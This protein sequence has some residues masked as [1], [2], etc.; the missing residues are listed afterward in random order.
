MPRPDF[1]ILGAPKCGTTAMYRWLDA[2]PGVFMP[3]KE[4]HHWGGDLHHRRATLT[5]EAYQALFDDAGP[6]QVVGEVAV[7]YLMSQAAPDELL[8]FAPD[9]RV[10][11]M[12][13]DPVEL[14]HSLHSQLLYSGEED[15]ADLADALAAETDRRAG[16]RIPT[17]TH[18]GL[19]APPDECLH[20]RRVVDFAPQ[21][22]RWREAY[23]DRLLVL[24]HDDLRA[25]QAATFAQVVDFIGADRGFTPDF[26]VVNPN[27]V[28]KNQA[29]R[30]LIQGLRW[31]PWNRLVPTGR[32][33]TAARRGFE[34]LQ[35]MNTSY[36][37][38]DSL[39]EGLRAALLD[40]LLPGIDA[41]ETELGRDLS[42]WKH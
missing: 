2:H 31:G 27:K 34:K 37:R 40:E 4:L 12:L 33:R 17:S 15:I 36:Q 16:R 18:T 8:A 10:I 25:D 7:W 23:G 6:D 29:A 20:Y 13:R 22:R 19:E 3:A 42:A 39:D 1:F 35:A 28:A 11:A 32:V 24:L 21:V 26:S 9:A 38:R 14:I 30:R 41:L 5:Q